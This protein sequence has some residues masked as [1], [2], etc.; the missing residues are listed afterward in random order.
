MTKRLWMPFDIGDYLRDTNHLT[1][2]EH[3]AYLMLIMH[4]W[5]HGGLP[6]DEAM[7]R[8]VAKMTAE[9]WTESRDLLASLFKDGWRHKRID[10]EL[11]K[12]DELVEK[13]RT[14]AS[15]QHQ[16]RRSSADAVQV[17]RT[18]SD[19]SV[20]PRTKNQDTA[21]LRSAETRAGRAE[22]LPA[23]W[24]LPDG[25]GQDAIDVGL[26]ADLIDLEAAKMRDWSLASPKGACKDW[27]ARWRNWCREA[28]SRQP[29]A[30][31]GSRKPP[32]LADRA[33]ELARQINEAQHVRSSESSNGV[34]TPVPNLP[35]V[36]SG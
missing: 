24:K 17:H 36:P 22:R 35:L 33:H 30:G 31:P 1:V 16:K 25:W 20:P 13:R 12:A 26:P 3:G 34:R 6:A 9:Q 29:R 23:D 8:R 18:Y 28:S 2:T 32:R 27:R 4:Y 21:S 19:A 7:I 5:Q 11:A 10:E 14:N 15:A